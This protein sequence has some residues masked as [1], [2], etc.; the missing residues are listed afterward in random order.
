MHV[1]WKIHALL[2]R[3]VSLRTHAA[4]SVH[5]TEEEQID[6]RELQNGLTAECFLRER[7]LQSRIRGAVTSE[8]VFLLFRFIFL[9]VAV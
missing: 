6:D 3:N 7:L 1:E 9:I 8:A 5:Q 2:R 4:D